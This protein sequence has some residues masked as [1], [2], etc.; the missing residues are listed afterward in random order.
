[1]RT[2]TRSIMAFTVVTAVASMATSA[3]ADDVFLSFGGEIVG[4]STDPNH[5][6]EIK[7]ASY[8]L[9]TTAV[10]AFTPG[11]GVSV[12]KPGY[13]P[14]R[15][16]AERDSSTLKMLEHISTGNNASTATLTVKPKRGSDSLTYVFSNV[17]FT[18]VGQGAV[19]DRPRLLIDGTFIY[20]S[21]SIQS[22]HAGVV[23]CANFDVTTG[24]FSEVC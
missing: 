10:V 6:G 11:G 24:V 21:V 9:E 3:M 1:M 7:L 19:P 2:L 20:K 23:T 22:S 8:S 5:P 17:F 14:L 15:F 16:T 18:G 12:G 4:D 13:G